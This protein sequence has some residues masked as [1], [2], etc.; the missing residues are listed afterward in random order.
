MGPDIMESSRRKV[1]KRS[2]TKNTCVTCGSS[3]EKML[4]LTDINN[5]KVI[6]NAAQLRRNERILALGS[7]DEM[8]K[9]MMYGSECR[10]SFVHKRAMDRMKI[11]MSK[12]AKVQN[13]SESKV[14][15]KRVELSEDKLVKP[16]DVP[17]KL[18]TMRSEDKQVK[19]QNVPRKPK[20][21]RSEDKQV[22]PQN[23][24]RK[25]KTL[26]S[27]DK[28]V[29]PQN[30]PGKPKTLHSED[31]QVKP[32]N[33]PGKPKTLHSEDKQVKPQNV[34]GKPK[35]LHSEDKQ[36]KPQNVPGKLKILHSEDKQVKPQ[37]VPGKLKILHSEDKQEEPQN[38]FQV[39]R[40][41]NILHNKDKQEK[42]LNENVK[43]LC[44]NK[45]LTVNNRV[46][47]CSLKDRLVA[48][49]NKFKRQRDKVRQI[50]SKK[51]VQR[52]RK[53]KDASSILKNF[54][55]WNRVIN[56]V[57]DMEI[58][59]FTCNEQVANETHCSCYRKYTQSDDNNIRGKRIHGQQQEMDEDVCVSYE[60]VEAK[61]YGALF[62]YIREKSFSPD[63]PSEVL[64]LSDL[65]DLLCSNIIASGIRG[66]HDSTKKNVKRKIETEF[67][68]S[69]LF[70]KTDSGIVYLMRSTISRKDTDKRLDTQHEE[71]QTEKKSVCC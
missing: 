43:L 5:W 12:L 60:S 1:K 62:K 57:C 11:K 37:N 13:S 51:L 22:K 7:A 19:P 29:K 40:K 44:K 18:K 48:S 23:V 59:K 69:V 27:E 56:A 2:S 25:P 39:P 47:K 15:L 66:V 24:P 17:R 34:P 14:P 54:H 8:P 16:Q 49:R 46:L 32:Q 58:L 36:V 9:N 65:I 30:V 64:A 42:P 33:V 71:E 52:R 10:K 55:A 4:P 26:R 20:T 68:E 50:R 6:W 3:H 41:P 21:L 31:K 53:I 28:Q 45:K 38:E 70:V 67:G 35:T 63:H 61:A